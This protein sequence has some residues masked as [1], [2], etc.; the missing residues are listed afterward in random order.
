M[1]KGSAIDVRIVFS[2]VTNSIAYH[3]YRGDLL[4]V[5]S[6]SGAT[7]PHDI[8]PGAACGSTEVFDPVL[9]GPGSFY[10]LASAA[11]AAGEGPLGS[12]SDGTPRTPKPASG[13]PCP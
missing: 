10:Y 11:N 5:A 8:L 7:P 2:R 4:Q 3:C 9:T 12:G 6:V 1:D 13:T